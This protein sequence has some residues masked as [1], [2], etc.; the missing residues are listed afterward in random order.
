[1]DTHDHGPV[2]IG[3]WPEP[4]RRFVLRLRTAPGG[5]GPPAELTASETLV[6]NALAVRAHRRVLPR[7]ELLLLFRPADRHGADAALPELLET[8]AA[9]LAGRAAIRWRNGGVMLADADAGI[10]VRHV[11]CDD[12]FEVAAILPRR[13]ALRG[14]P[15]AGHPFQSFRRG[16]R[17]MLVLAPILDSGARSLPGRSLAAASGTTAP[18]K[19]V[20]ALRALGFPIAGGPAGY[21]FPA[22]QPVMRIDR[23]NCRA[24]IGDR[25]VR[26]A[27]N[28]MTL[29]DC[30]ATAG[31]PV[32]AAEI[33]HA[34]WQGRADP[35][36]PRQLVRA[37]RRRLASLG[38][39][40]L[41]V[42]ART[43]DGSMGYVLRARVR[44]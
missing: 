32:P 18:H 11:R 9:K 14:C 15:D 30:L 4:E 13:R 19:Q 8:L 34:I 36:A 6:L 27:W 39:P 37:L 17:S 25:D 1:M 42:T 38:A 31:R 12:G 24:S 20:T 28:E 5:F 26:L 10:L 40:S 41:V 33:L 3:Q 21:R 2:S 43:A 23:A 35:S 16:A 29:L 7:A 22:P 44:G